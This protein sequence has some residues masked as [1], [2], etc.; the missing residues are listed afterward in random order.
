[1]NLKKNLENVFKLVDA[2]LT[3]TRT[4]AQN[5]LDCVKDS[6]Q[7]RHP[8]SHLTTNT[9]DVWALSSFS[10]LGVFPPVFGQNLKRFK[11]NG[12]MRSDMVQLL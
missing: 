6:M 1:M 3:A 9:P 2:V 5:Q 10:F 11:I 12:V 8:N 7:N 4:Y